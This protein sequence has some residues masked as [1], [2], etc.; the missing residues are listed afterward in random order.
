MKVLD[1][2]PKLAKGTVT[3]PLSIAVIAHLKRCGPC[4]LSM[5][6]DTF[7]STTDAEVI[8]MAA[9][10]RK[11][12]LAGHVHVV[13]VS[14]HHFWAHGPD[15]EDEEEAVPAVAHIAPP[16]RVNVMAGCYVPPRNAVMRPGADHRH[17]QSRGLRC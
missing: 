5:L 10:L 11:L 14:G 1:T 12:R 6:T 16:R 8:S 13:R 17:L 9:R 3:S 15:E 2:T 4:S 7:H